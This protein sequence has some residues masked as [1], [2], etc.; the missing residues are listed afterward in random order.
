MQDYRFGNRLYELRKKAG[1]SQ[2]DLGKKIDLS[3]KAVS[4]WE[5]GQ[6]KPGLDTVHKLADVLSVSVDDLLETGAN[7]KQITKIVITGGPCA[8][9]T[10]AMSWIQNAFTKRGYAVLFVDETATQLITGGAAPWLSTS[11]RDFQWQ[12]IQLQQAKEKAFTEIGKTLKESKVLIVCDRAVMDNCAYMTDAEFGWVLKRMQT[13]KI[14]LRDQY[15]AVFHLVTAAKGAE[16]YYTLANN[17]ARTETVE[18]ASALDDKLIAAW[19]GHPHFRVID[20]STGFEEKMMR[21]IRE[22]TAFLGEPTPMEIE[23]KYLISRPNLYTL[24][25]LP[26]CEKVDII[27]TYLLS[28]D[29]AEEIRI[30]QR[31]SHGSYIYFMTRK[32]KVSALKRVE[33]E[34]RL[35]Q[36]E[37]LA[38]MVQADPAY[39]SIHKQRYCLSEN[40]MYYEIDIFPDWKDKALMEIEL[41]SESQ[42]VIFPEGID[43]IRE[44]TDDPAYSNH[45]L[46]KIK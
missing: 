32:R 37:Y 5:N 33:I 41:H 8:G 23:R 4:K 39:R 27:Q 22:I 20:N 30:R 31:G 3:N 19:T 36:N 10:T 1:L 2:A 17:Q 14:A 18:Q 15:D 7:E 11:N 28:E 38:L 43:I 46:A 42:E 21:L 40:G 16:K 25:Q 29:P 6:A 44:V 26:N 13:S 45:E 35:T 24:E 12:L 34:E 9:K